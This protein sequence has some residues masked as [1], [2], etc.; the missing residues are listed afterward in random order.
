VKIA[1][2]KNQVEYFGNKI[3]NLIPAEFLVEALVLF[4]I[5]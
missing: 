5:L 2:T 3:L 1:T 4:L